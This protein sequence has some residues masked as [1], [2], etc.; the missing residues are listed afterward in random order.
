MASKTVRDPK[1]VSRTLERVE[2]RLEASQELPEAY[3]LAIIEQAQGNAGLRPTPQAPMA[4]E[5]LYFENGAILSLPGDSPAA[6]VAIGSEFGSVLYPQFGPRNE[7]GYWLLPAVES[8]SG[9]AEAAGEAVIDDI[10]ADEVRR[11]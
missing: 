9:A 2:D 11:A 10:V 3:A 6:E 1:R 7:R 4:A 5:G 8:P